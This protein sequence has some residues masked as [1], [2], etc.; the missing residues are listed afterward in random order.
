VQL[1]EVVH[2]QLAYRFKLFDYLRHQLVLS[3]I[4]FKPRGVVLLRFIGKILSNNLVDLISFAYLPLDLV[5][6]VIIAVDIVEL[7]TVLHEFLF[8]GSPERNVFL[9]YSAIVVV[10]LLV[11]D[12]RTVERFAQ[13]AIGLEVLNRRVV[14][15]D[16]L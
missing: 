5:D 15:L 16:V 12:V 13:I 4:L 3:E 2:L 11:S 1:V 10:P 14:L 7:G 8:V 9:L 6:K